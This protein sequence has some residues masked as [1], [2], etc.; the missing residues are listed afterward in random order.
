MQ[1]VPVL[2][3]PQGEVVRKKDYDNMMHL[4]EARCERYIQL[5]LDFDMKEMELKTVKS[6]LETSL[7]DVTNKKSHEKVVLWL[8][9]SVPIYC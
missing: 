9:V 8:A 6:K 3:L 4:L 2:A 7:S 1:N 5:Q